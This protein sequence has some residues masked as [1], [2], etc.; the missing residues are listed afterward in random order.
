MRKPPIVAVGLDLHTTM[1]DVIA[2]YPGAGPVLA[3]RG[4]AC[5]GCPMARFE[6]VGEAASAYGFD[7]VELLD[8][9][10]RRTRAGVRRAHHPVTRRR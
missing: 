9:L 3:R 4:M 6:T 7:P 2:A 1:A 5:V 8:E 10:R